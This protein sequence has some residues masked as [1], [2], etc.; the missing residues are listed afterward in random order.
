M[1]VAADNVRHDV[2][3]VRSP[4]FTTLLQISSRFL[5][6]H[7]I[8]AP[9][10]VSTRPSPAYT[11]MLLAWGITEVIRYSYFVFNLSGAG[12]PKVWSWLRYNSFLVLYPIGVGSE[13]WLV[14]RAS[15]VAGQ[16]ERWGMWAVLGI[17][18]P[19]FWVLFGHMVRQR[20]RVMR[21]L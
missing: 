18:V 3:I 20:A 5:L 8:A 6:V 14:W 12:V 4:L 7:F 1:N 16:W 11:T 9:Y 19:G 21:S 2:G 10:A 13:C 15:T 17:Y